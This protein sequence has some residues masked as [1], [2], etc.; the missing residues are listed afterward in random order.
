MLGFGGVYFSILITMSI[1]VEV[2]F[3]WPGIGRLAL[4]AI[5][6]KD[7]PVLQGVILVTG[8]VVIGVNFLVD[9]LYAFVDPR[10][11]FSKV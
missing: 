4:N 7:F 9:F 8:V 11:R 10:I 1:V 2:V 6:L 3:A 5:S